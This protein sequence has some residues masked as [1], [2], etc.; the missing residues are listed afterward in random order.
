MSYC[1]PLV[2]CGYREAELLFRAMKALTPDRAVRVIRILD[3]PSNLG[4]K[5]PAPDVVPGVYK[6]PWALREAGIL[7]ELGAVDA[8]VVVPPRYVA[9]WKPRR[10]TLP[11]RA[12]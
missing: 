6:A 3:A 12:A 11:H 2:A 10:W 1:D 8:G 5:P 7:A 4:L 9:T